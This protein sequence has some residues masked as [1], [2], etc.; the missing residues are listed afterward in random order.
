MNDAN[1]PPYTDLQLDTR[2]I[3]DSAP[4]WINQVAP[5]AF[6]I[7][8]ATGEYLG[9]CQADPSP[10]EPGVWL[11][12]A[13][14]VTDAP[15]I[16]GQ[17]QAVVRENGAWTVV[18]DHRGAT[19][20]HTATGE[21]RTWLLLG[22]LPADYTLT[23]PESAF[24]KWEAGQWQLDETAQLAAAKDLATRKRALLLQYASTQV[25]ALQDAVDLDIATD[26][27]AKALKSWK[28]YRVQL[29]RLDTI[30]AV[31]A[32][33]DWPTSPDPAATDRYLSANG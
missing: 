32:E 23:A 7:E 11:F 16:A 20:Y 26:A 4:W 28:T 19:A 10:L 27:E 25:A 13:H 17:G 22:A 12:P 33:G 1:L 6:N 2:E 18:A 9:A 31:P 8:P 29:N 15:P 24:D 5:Q 21:P 3:Q 30:G 14:S